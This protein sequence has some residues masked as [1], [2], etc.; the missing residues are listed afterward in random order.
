MRHTVT[1]A[2]LSLL[3][4]GVLSAIRVSAQ[5]ASLVDLLPAAAEIGPSFVV[6]EDRSRSLDDQ[7]SGFANASDAAQSLTDWGWQEN[8]FRVYQSA[9]LTNTGQPVATVDISL[10]RFASEDGARLA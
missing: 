3:V 7:A 5:N 1:L 10:T 8:V 2:L 9:E 6:T 4:L